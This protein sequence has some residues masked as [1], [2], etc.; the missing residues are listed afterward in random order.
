MVS[1]IGNS[2]KSYAKKYLAPNIKFQPI[3]NKKNIN[4]YDN[5]QSFFT[6]LEFYWQ[7][8]NN[9]VNFQ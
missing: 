2:R 1:T 8:K 9:I 3:F 5:R 4:I 7:N 6:G